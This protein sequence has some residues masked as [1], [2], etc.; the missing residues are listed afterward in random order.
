M[1]VPAL[2]LFFQKS[3]TVQQYIQIKLQP[4]D[5]R[6]KAAQHKHKIK[7]DNMR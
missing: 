7:H 3:I 4:C 6:L 2:N 1:C 5:S